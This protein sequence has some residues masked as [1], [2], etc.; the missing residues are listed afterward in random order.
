MKGFL[1]NYQLNLRKKEIDPYDH[2]IENKD[3]FYQYVAFENIAKIY[4]NKVGFIKKAKEESGV[5][6]L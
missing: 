2:L 4:D 5:T 3:S 1:K 6:Q